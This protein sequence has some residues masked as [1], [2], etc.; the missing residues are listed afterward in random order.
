M[1]NLKR[2]IGV[3]FICYVSSCAT[4]SK[5][6]ETAYE[7]KV[8]EY[9]SYQQDLD[10]LQRFTTVDLLQ[11]PAGKGMIAV[12]PA[13]QARVMTSSSDGLQ[14]RS[15]GWINRDLF[16]S[17]DT[18]DHINPFGGE[19]RLWLGPEGGQFSIF[20][21]KETKF[22]LTNWQTP[23]F[24][25]LE[26]FQ[27]K[28]KSES[29]ALYEH[30]AKVT[31]YSGFTF[32][33]NIQRH[34]EVL[35]VSEIYQSLGLAKNDDLKMVGYQTTNTLTNTG[36]VSW[37]KETGLLSIWLLGMFNP[38]EATTI[39]VP[40]FEGD[41]T[42]MGRV[43]NDSYFGKVPAERLKIGKGVLFF[44][45]D[46]KYRSK[47]GLLP[48]R[49][50]D[51]LGSYDANSKTLTIV[52]YSKPEYVTEYVNSKWEI[53]VNPYGGDVINSYNDGPTEDGGKPLGPFYELE[54]S[55]PALSLKSGETGTHIQRTFHFEGKEVGLDK[56]AVKLLGVSLEEIRTAL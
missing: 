44:S 47:I 3:A 17:G 27:L 18:L 52:T 7:D 53:Q 15:Y 29:S 16:E 36:S 51:I 34:I 55:S 14:G 48:K 37:N 46:G 40:F 45:G 30:D 1:K 42:N 2:V 13:L 20:F 12:S 35:S 24:I 9:T 25:D 10:F 21:K 28:S 49:A 33:I 38:S 31:N 43:V 32:D 8:F 26:A 50:K 54:T 22:N 19:E 5:K 56:I 4:E 41:S 39:V 23:A 6:N 11:E